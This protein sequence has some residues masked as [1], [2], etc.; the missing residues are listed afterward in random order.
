[1]DK[2]FKEKLCFPLGVAGV[3]SCTEC[4]LPHV[5]QQIAGENEVGEFLVGRAHYLATYTLPFLIAF[6]NKYDIF[7]NTH[8]G[9]HIVG[10][11]DGGHIILLGDGVE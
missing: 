10:I 3:G 9:V 1:M 7:A 8:H 11:D 6:V 5:L 2:F 4:H